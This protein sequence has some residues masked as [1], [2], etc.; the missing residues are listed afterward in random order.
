MFVKLTDGRVAYTDNDN[1]FFILTD[2]LFRALTNSGSVASPSTTSRA[3]ATAP[4]P[5]TPSS[6]EN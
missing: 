6:S 4:R 1:F 5:V 3:A 2:P